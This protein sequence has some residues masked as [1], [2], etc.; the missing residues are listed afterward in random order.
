LLFLKEGFFFSRKNI[1][2]K[3]AWRG[4]LMDWYKVAQQLEF[5]FSGEYFLEDLKNVGFQPLEHG[6]F[7]LRVGNTFIQGEPDALI[8]KLNFIIERI[9]QDGIFLS[10]LVQK[11][12]DIEG[13]IRS[14]E[15]MKLTDEEKKEYRDK[16]L[17][18]IR[19]LQKS[20][21][22]DKNKIAV[23]DK[24]EDIAETFML[25]PTWVISR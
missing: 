23:R 25:N 15:S 13:E 6:R 22:S 1:L 19:G 9:R 14:R 8:S 21:I 10:N 3:Q 24:I 12:A 18:M 2:N 5:D 4:I 17:H 16:I 20:S 11:V 7:S